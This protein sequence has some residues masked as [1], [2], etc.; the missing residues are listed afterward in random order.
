MG[1]NLKMVFLTFKPDVIFSL[2]H[3]L[4]MRLQAGRGFHFHEKVLENV[5]KNK[6]ILEKAGYR[7][8]TVWELLTSLVVSCMDVLLPVITR[9]VNSSLTTGHFPDD[10]KKAIARPLLKSPGLSANF[11]NLPP[12]VICSMFLS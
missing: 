11:L 3:I 10:W 8:Y 1:N 2:F 12:K 6:P 5:S 4:S 9:M 7:P